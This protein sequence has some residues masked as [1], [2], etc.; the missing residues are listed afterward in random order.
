MATRPR[1]VGFLRGVTEGAAIG[2]IGVVAALLTE[3]DLGQ[4][5]IALPVIMLGA[6]T[7][8]G[9]VDDRIDPTVQR[10]RLGGT[11]AEVRRLEPAEEAH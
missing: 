9:F 6:R 5:N 7:L 10:G 4:W 11:P 8:E 1:V 2:A 3:L